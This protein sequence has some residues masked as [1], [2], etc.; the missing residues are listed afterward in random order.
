MAGFNLGACN[1]WVKKRPDNELFSANWRII[2]ALFLTHLELASQ[3]FQTKRLWNPASCCCFLIKCPQRHIWVCFISLWSSPLPDTYFSL[4]DGNDP[5][6]FWWEFAASCIPTDRETNRFGNRSCCFCWNALQ[7]MNRSKSHS[8]LVPQACGPTVH[9]TCGENTY[10][11]GYCFLLDENLRQIKH[12][13]DVL[14]GETRIAKMQW[15]DGRGKQATRVPSSAVV[16]EKYSFSK[17][18][19]KRQ[20]CSQRCISKD[21]KGKGITYHIFAC[22]IQ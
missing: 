16:L 21:V 17:T 7:R 20:K 14:P 18:F 13:P 1:I 9:Q 12:F 11:K 5:G 10:L 6:L 22:Y 8:P 2:N 4:L 15:R 3:G 19:P